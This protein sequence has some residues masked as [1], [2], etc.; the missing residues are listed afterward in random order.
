M[1]SYNFHL[2]A[3]RGRQFS[4]VIDTHASIITLIKQKKKY[5][6]PKTINIVQITSVSCGRFHFMF[7]ANVFLASLSFDFILVIRQ[8]VRIISEV[9]F[10]SLHNCTHVSAQLFLYS[11]CTHICSLQFDIKIEMN[12]IEC[13]CGLIDLFLM[14]ND[15]VFSVLSQHIFQFIFKTEN[16]RRQRKRQ[17]KRVNGFKRPRKCI[18]RKISKTIYKS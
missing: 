9:K 18:E 14:K 6:E 4:M 5:R 1:L 7:V 2:S 10:P 16:Y 8:I 12:R 13:H 17:Q 11:F 15:I 3:I